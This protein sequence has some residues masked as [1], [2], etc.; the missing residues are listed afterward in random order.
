MKQPK[1]VGARKGLKV[2]TSSDPAKPRYSLEELIAGITPENV[3]PATDWGPAVG[4][5]RFWDDE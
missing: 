4:R 1:P 5:E 3:H 2:K